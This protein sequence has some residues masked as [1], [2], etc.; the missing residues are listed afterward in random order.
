MSP[1]GSKLVASGVG[2]NEARFM[3]SKTS[4][5]EIG[6][7]GQLIA[8]VWEGEGLSFLELAV[9]ERESLT[10]EFFFFWHEE[11]ESAMIAV[12]SGFLFG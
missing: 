1:F 4:L 10:S 5:Y 2:V 6:E 11:N 12:E 3:R 7:L 8:E 9:P